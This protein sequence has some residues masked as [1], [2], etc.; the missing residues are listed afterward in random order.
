MDVKRFYVKRDNT[1]EIKCPY[2]Q[3]SKTVPVEKFK[4][5]KNILQI[6]CLCKKVFNVVHEFRQMY[7][8]GT[9][10][11]GRYFNQ[12]RDNDEGRIVVDNISLKGVGF[13]TVGLH[14][15]K[16]DHILNVEYRI[17]DPQKT[18]ISRK[19][20]AR[21]VKGDYVGAECVNV[22]EYD[23]FLDFYLLP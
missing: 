10:L 6:S 19:V 11:R 1:V 18:L 5:P 21:V 15:I 22:G 16:K 8:K 2:C 12:S 14:K 13:Y 4:N 20:I 17:D 9:K 23:K 7:R 3:A